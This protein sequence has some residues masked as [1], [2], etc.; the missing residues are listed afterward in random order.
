MRKHF[1]YLVWL[2][3][4]KLYVFWAGLK[5]GVPILQLLAH[6]LSKFRPDEWG[7]YA[8]YFYGEARKLP[9]PEDYP[10]WGDVKAA[11]EMAWLLHQ[12]RN[13]HHWQYWVLID[14]DGTVTA[15]QM[16]DK[17]LY[18]MIA[19]WRGAG[20]AITGKWGALEWYEANKEH[21]NL[22]EITRLDVETCLSWEK[23]KG[24]KP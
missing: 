15:L 17:Y 4:H 22:H 24:W 21:I 12:R 5:L 18:E 9:K 3:R 2:L 19:D 16:P 1:A 20:R 8:E 11:E 14:D 23:V 6:D 7:P 13:P 10:L